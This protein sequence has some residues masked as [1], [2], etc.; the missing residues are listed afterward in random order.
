MKE[1]YKNTYINKYIKYVYMIKVKEF[2]KKYLYFKKEYINE[3]LCNYLN[4]YDDKT[5]IDFLR[6]SIKRIFPYSNNY[7]TDN[8]INYIY[9]SNIEYSNRVKIV[10]NKNLISDYIETLTDDRVEVDL[11]RLSF[12]KNF[13]YQNNGK[14]KKHSQ[15]QCIDVKELSHLRENDVY[16]YNFDQIM[17]KDEF[18]NNVMSENKFIKY[19]IHQD[20]HN[21][22]IN[23]ILVSIMLKKYYRNRENIEATLFQLKNIK[24]IYKYINKDRNQIEI[25]YFVKKFFIL[26]PTITDIPIEKSID[27]FL[28]IKLE[29]NIT[30]NDIELFI[31][32]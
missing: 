18:I 10:L 20:I 15:I 22:I 3:S 25:L 21:S 26:D 16:F 8:F 7:D 9:Q 11:I 23:P 30:D 31:T 27:P 6:D 24:Q 4:I 13:I 12:T 19:L 32:Y 29:M 5:D 14:I 17:N 1:I 2:K 28:I